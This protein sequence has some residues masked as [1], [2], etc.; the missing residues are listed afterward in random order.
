MT[1][2]NRGG[3]AV[4]A[5]ALAALL[6]GGGCGPRNAYLPPPPPEVEV[7]VPV[8]QTVTLY[9]EFTGTT[10]ASDT[11]QVRSRVQG[12]LESVHFLDGADVRK[13]DLLFVID[14]QPYQAQMDQAQ[15]DLESKKA[16]AVRAEALYR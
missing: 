13:G 8:E 9:D 3:P 15:A 4:L 1:D 5:G 6:G 10:Q 12:Y 11:V 16:A 7:A 14:R 2:R